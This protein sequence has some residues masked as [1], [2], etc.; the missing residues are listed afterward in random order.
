MQWNLILAEFKGIGKL[1]SY[2]KS[3]PSLSQYDVLYEC[4]QTCRPGTL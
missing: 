2:I 4:S 1:V 3:P